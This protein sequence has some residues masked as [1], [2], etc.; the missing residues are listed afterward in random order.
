MLLTNITT[1]KSEKLFQRI[2]LLQF[3][4]Y[5]IKMYKTKL[6]MYFMSG[7]SKYFYYV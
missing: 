6:S 7:E 3:E 4:T 1:G 2:T 5:M